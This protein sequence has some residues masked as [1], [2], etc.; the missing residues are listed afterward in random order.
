MQLLDGKKLAEAQYQRFSR[1]V[2]QE[3]GR[4]VRPPRLTAFMVAP[5]PASRLYVRNKE[6]ACKK[7]GAESLVVEF[8]YEITTEELLEAVGREAESGGTDG[9][10]VQ[11]P[12]PP[13]ID[14]LAVLAAIPA[15]MDA[16]GFSPASQGALALDIAGH[17]PAT[18]D[19]IMMLLDAYGIQ[20]AG[21]HAVVV[22]RSEIVGTPVALLLSRRGRD[23]TVTMC[24]S[25]TTDL[26][27]FTRQ[28]DLLIVA[29]GQPE[30]IG[31]EHLK[32][33]VVVIDVGI[34]A[35]AT[36][37][38]TSW[39]GDVRFDEVAP[40]VSAITPVPGGVGPMTV[41]AL[42]RNTLRAWAARFGLP[43]AELEVVSPINA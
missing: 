27:A 29:A 32:H 21:R 23:S 19:G 42:I 1:Y 3:T 18:P 5:E 22:G 17:R 33:G 20:T 2:A 12:L 9:L 11:L 31:V 6:K 4:N 7:I 16:D 37:N 39:V 34:H 38:G 36:E 35:K 14:R 26:P 25:R 41:C 40:L 24:H 30:M 43:T 10:I 28:A 13:H 8:P 15:F